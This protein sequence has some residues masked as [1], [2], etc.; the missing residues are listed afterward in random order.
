MKHRDHGQGEENRGFYQ[1]LGREVA[2]V[3]TQE[4]AFIED[5]RGAYSMKTERKA[6]M[7]IA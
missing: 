2:A 6:V 4:G 7:C 5:N 3:I 1:A